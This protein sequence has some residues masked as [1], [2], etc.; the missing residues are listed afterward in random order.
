MEE[1]SAIKNTNK[2][3]GEWSTPCII[4]INAEMKTALKATLPEK[5]AVSAEMALYRQ[6]YRIHLSR[7]IRLWE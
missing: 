7:L 1:K 2:S 4:L 3:T 5:G 6:A